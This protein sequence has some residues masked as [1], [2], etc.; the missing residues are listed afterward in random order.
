MK[1]K[2]R[3]DNEYLA[4]SIWMASE[5]ALSVFLHREIMPR[6]KYV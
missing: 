3:T 2:S 4:W 6:L 1:N 5:N